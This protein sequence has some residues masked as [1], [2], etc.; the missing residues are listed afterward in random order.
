V[1]S[2]HFQEFLMPELQKH[3]YTAVYK[4]KTTELYTANK[5]AIDGCATFFRKDRFALVK[6]YEAGPPRSSRNCTSMQ[7]ACEGCKSRIGRLVGFAWSSGGS[8]W[9]RE[10]IS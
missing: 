2:N 10:T 8:S 6:K 1:Q 3:G 7:S 4:K 5:F 9:V